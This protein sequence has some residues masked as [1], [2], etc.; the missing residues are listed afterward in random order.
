[1]DLHLLACCS[2]KSNEEEFEKLAANRAA[3]SNKENCEAKRIVFL[4]SEPIKID[5]AKLEQLSRY[6]MPDFFQ[7]NQTG[8]SIADVPQLGDHI[9]A[10]CPLLTIRSRAK[11]EVAALALMNELF[12]AVQDW[13]V[14]T[15]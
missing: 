3:F 8:G 14:K 6:Y 10:G 11:T 7:S 5:K 9:E 2:T 13:V 4:G 12:V 15:G 1:M